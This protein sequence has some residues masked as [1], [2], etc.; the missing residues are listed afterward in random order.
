MAIQGGKPIAVLDTAAILCKYINPNFDNYTVNRVV[1]ELQG[2]GIDFTES[3]FSP[4]VNV[5]EPSRAYIDQAIRFAA[6]TGDI[7]ILSETDFALLGLALE[8][9]HTRGHIVE[10]FTDDYALANVS[11]ALGFNHTFV[12]LRKP[13]FKTMRWIWYCPVCHR[14]YMGS[15]DAICLECG[16]QL[17]RKPKH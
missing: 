15:H 12:G 7:R 8:L 1:V 13:D 3:Y 6:K 17:K 2:F 10:L 9:R 4:L 14:T 11:S 5:V 16:T